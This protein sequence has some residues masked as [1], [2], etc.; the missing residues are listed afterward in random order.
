[1]EQLHRH[2]I[3]EEATKVT[4]AEGLTPAMLAF[5]EDMMVLL[6]AEIAAPRASP[7]DVL[8]DTAKLYKK[9]LG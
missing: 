1:M 3:Q 4:T 5:L 9:H 8:A 2:I 6:D 7:A